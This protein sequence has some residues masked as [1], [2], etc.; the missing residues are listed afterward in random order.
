MKYRI[1]T[2]DSWL[3][4]DHAEAPERAEGLGASAWSANNH[5]SEVMRQ[6]TSRIW[7]HENEQIFSAFQARRKLSRSPQSGMKVFIIVMLDHDFTH[8]KLEWFYDHV[9]HASEQD[10]QR[11]DCARFRIFFLKE[12]DI[13]KM[14]LA[15]YE[16]SHSWR[17]RGKL[18][19]RIAT[20]FPSLVSYFWHLQ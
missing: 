11:I 4:A 12:G 20:S 6:H 18:K 10:L 15:R 5:E 1:M 19:M 9:Q 3:L 16:F 2:E 14:I 13:F 17:T 8:I 7:G